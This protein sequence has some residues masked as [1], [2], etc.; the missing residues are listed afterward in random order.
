[1]SVLIDKL[2]VNFLSGR[3]ERFRWI[4][5]NLALCRCPFCGDGKKGTRTRFYIYENVKYGSTAYNVECKNCGF[6]MSFHNFLKDWDPSLFREYRLEKF[7]D[8]FGRE[9]RQMFQEQ[10]TETSCVI[11]PKLET[12]DL[13]GTI[14]LSELSDDHPCVEYVKK[15]M[16]PDK[17]MD[18]LMYTDNFREV[19]A[20]FKDAEYAEKMPEDNRLI[21]P[22]YNEFGELL[23]YQ[24]RSLNSN[25]RIRY[26]T[27]KKHDAV[28]KVFGMDMIDRSEDVRVCE[29]PIDSMFIK[30]CLASADA[31]LTK[32]DGD[33]Y[34]FDA[35]YRNKDV[36]KQ[37]QKA[38]DSGVKVVLFPKEFIWKDVNE[39][40]TDGGLTMDDIENVINKNTFQGL[41]A[42]LVFGKLKGS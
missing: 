5:S 32:I 24:G 4:R 28:T 29:G 15:R 34:I 37:I 26:I 1:M 6:S 2:Y 14:K 16:I 7:R 18:Y 33:V 8:K 17:Y 22:F 9:S 23:C 38:I 3:L 41:K 36:C 20:S 21:I 27:V 19:T 10:V 40:I 31:D 25:D 13:V 35:Q 30:N 12:I 11:D 39:A 42:K